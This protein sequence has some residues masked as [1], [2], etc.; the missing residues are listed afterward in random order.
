MNICTYASTL[1]SY[2]GISSTSSKNL[3]RV[4]PSI[5]H[6][7]H[8]I[9]RQNPAENLW[10]VT[11]HTRQR[12]FICSHVTVKQKN[13]NTTKTLRT[14]TKPIITSCLWMRK[15]ACTVRLVVGSSKAPWPWPWIGSRSNQ[16]TR[17]TC[18]S[19]CR[20]NHVTVAV[21]YTHLTLP[22]NREV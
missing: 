15:P 9:A 16:H 21:S 8:C 7:V 20:S 3:S 5:V 1:P 14:T 17:S 22:T 11:D 4:L 2:D 18:R 12:V 10:Q 6:V 13:R 19:T